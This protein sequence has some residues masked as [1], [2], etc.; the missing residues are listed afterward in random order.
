MRA[1]CIDIGS[2]TT[3]LLVAEWLDG[4][5]VQVHQERAF[6]HIRREISGSDSIGD[7][8]LI[9]VAEIVRR[10]FAVASELGAVEVR[11]V[12]TAAI[13][14]A[15]NREQFT[16]AIR[17][18]AGLDVE[19]L[20]AELEARLAF[21]GAAGM[22]DAPLSGDLCV[23]DVGGGSSELVV[24]AIP[25]QIWWWQ[26]LALGS[27][28]LADRW[29]N[30]DPPSEPELR[31]ARAEVA[32]VLRDC[33]PPRPAFAIAV[34]GSATS[35]SRLAGSVL[36][37]SALRRALAVLAGGPA[38]EVAARFELDPERVRLLPGALLILEAVGRLLKATIRV[39]R[40]GIREG[41]L[42]EALRP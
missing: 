12:A 35:L 41:V 26:S 30:S 11:A 25:D 33:R 2:N 9:E 7:D 38:G 42:L 28:A 5:L 6:T 23:L 8:K 29:L 15:A 31:A 40:G 1:G 18:V 22:L 37:T 39:G 4:R 27:G 21:C 20:S 13:R 17:R 10:Q 3:R 16:K 32:T 34:G 14:S 24:G 19:V 36:D